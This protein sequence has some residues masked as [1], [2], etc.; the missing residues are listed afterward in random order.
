MPLPG[1]GRG[2]SR[3]V[4][5]LRIDGS[6]GDWDA[7]E[8]LR[9]AGELSDTGFEDHFVDDVIVQDIGEGTGGWTFDGSSYSVELR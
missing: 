5:P 8:E 2:E 7:I 6:R 1:L 9:I 4:A 3:A